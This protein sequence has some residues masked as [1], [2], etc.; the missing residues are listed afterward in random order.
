M[1]SYTRV[2]P[3]DLFN[4]GSLLT[5]YGRLVIL[6]GETSGHDAAF[7]QEQVESFDVVQDDSSGSLTIANLVFTVRGE[8]YRLGRP[9]NSRE[10]WSLWLSSWDDPDFEEIAVFDDCG[11]FGPEMLALISTPGQEEEA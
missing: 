6:L 11:G 9:L 2:I 7:E 10:K 8:R 1:T 4:E 3:R 5:L